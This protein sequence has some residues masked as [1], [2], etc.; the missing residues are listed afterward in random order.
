[1]TV[2]VVQWTIDVEDLDLMSGLWCGTVVARPVGSLT[3]SSGPSI[4]A[5]RVEA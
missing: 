1:M 2:K 5:S 3:Y 4:V